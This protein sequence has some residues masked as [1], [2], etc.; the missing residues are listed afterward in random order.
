[1]NISLP[2]SLK[3]FVDQQVTDRGYG[4]SSEYVRELIRRDQDRQLLRGL[5]LEG[6]SSDPGTPADDDYFAAL[7]KRARGQ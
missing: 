5:L 7:R 3:Q 2:D 4:T 6:V 1:M